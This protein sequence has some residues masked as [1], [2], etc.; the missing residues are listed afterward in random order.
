VGG[1]CIGSICIDGY[2]DSV[3]CFIPDIGC[4]SDDGFAEETSESTVSAGD[5][6]VVK[7]LTAL[8][9]LLV[10]EFTARTFQ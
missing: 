1:G 3:L 5:G 10:L 4:D 6:S 2:G 8:Q 7:A 9:A